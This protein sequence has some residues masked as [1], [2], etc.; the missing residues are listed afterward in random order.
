M[1]GSSVESVKMDQNPIYGT[2]P[3]VRSNLPRFCAVTRISIKYRAQTDFDS[4]II[5]HCVKNEPTKTTQNCST[6]ELSYQ[7]SKQCLLCQIFYSN[8]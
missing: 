1:R 6:A 5:C 4:D 3:I 2:V 7:I 8:L